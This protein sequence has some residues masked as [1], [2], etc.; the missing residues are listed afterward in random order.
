MGILRHSILVISL[1]TMQAPHA[2]SDNLWNPIDVKPAMPEQGFAD[3][4]TY[5]NWTESI[6]DDR[7]LD[8]L[9]RDGVLPASRSMEPD[10]DLGFGLP[11][12]SMLD[13]EAGDDILEIVEAGRA[14]MSEAEDPVRRWCAVGELPSRADAEHGLRRNR[15]HLGRRRGLAGEIDFDRFHQMVFEVPAAVADRYDATGDGVPDHVVAADIGGVIITVV[16]RQ[17]S[18]AEGGS[19]R[20]GD[21][22]EDHCV[23]GRSAVIDDWIRRRRQEG[24]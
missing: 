17:G 11:K 14:G 2:S 5:R 1:S 9:S 20:R 19:F 8:F 21:G 22:R 10:Q 24:Y 3:S 18:T 16:E 6:D 23:L 13:G 4:E 7:Y 12:A 15:F